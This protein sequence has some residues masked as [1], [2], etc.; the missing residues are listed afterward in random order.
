LYCGTCCAW[1]NLS[2]KQNHYY[3]HKINIK[4]NFYFESEGNLITQLYGSNIKINEIYN[5]VNN[6]LLF[7]IGEIEINL[8]KNEE[9]NPTDLKRLIMQNEMILIQT[10]QNHKNFAKCY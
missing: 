1:K 10:R 3:I 2:V 8:K 4:I 7:F 5:I 6:G 9:I